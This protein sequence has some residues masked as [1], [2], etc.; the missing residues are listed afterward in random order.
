[1]SISDERDR[2]IH[3]LVVH[4]DML[5]AKAEE[6][7]DLFL[8]DKTLSRRSLTS[9]PERLWL[10]AADEDNEREVWFD[11]DEGG[12][13]YLRADLAALSRRS[14]DTADGVEEV[15][16]AA[17]ALC[18]AK[19]INP[20]AAHYGT[21]DRD[22]QDGT[23]EDGKPFYYGW[24]NQVKY[25][26]AVLASRPTRN[27]EVGV[28]KL[29]WRVNGDGWC[30]DTPFGLYDFSQYSARWAVYLSGGLLAEPESKEACERAAQADFDTR[31]R[32]AL[33]ITEPERGERKP[34]AV[35]AYPNCTCSPHSFCVPEVD[36][37]RAY[38]AAASAL[39]GSSAEIAVGELDHLVRV[40]LATVRGSSKMV[41]YEAERHA[42]NLE[43]VVANCIDNGP[44]RQSVKR[45]AAY[46]RSLITHSV[47]DFYGSFDPIQNA[48]AS[49]PAQEAVTDGWWPEGPFK[50]GD[51]V[52]K[53]KGS[54]WHGRVCGWYTTSFTP[55]GYNVE[56]ERELG[57]VQLYPAAA[58]QLGKKG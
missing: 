51:H 12:A 40:V 39:Q 15:E 46:L 5:R 52:E 4:F 27:A 21:S 22:E 56:S 37:K 6:A 3:I 9:E 49:P 33:A 47:T 53:I 30:A 57:S 17:R 50:F 58:L 43:R 36:V 32:S 38:D 16:R 25:A 41:D 42:V 31:I 14:L 2:L 45:A 13:P 10:G 20:D 11:P 26:L 44:A 18:V 55:V 28:R 19:G 1:M 24:R 35:C 8:H 7:A 48:L 34:D 23:F 29:E 54:S